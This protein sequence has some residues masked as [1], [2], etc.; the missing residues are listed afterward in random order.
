MGGGAASG[1][2]ADLRI[3]PMRTR[4]TVPTASTWC[5][6]G[7]RRRPPSSPHFIRGYGY[8]GSSEP[9][10]LHRSGG[11]WRRIQE[12]GKAGHLSHSARRLRRIARHASTT[13]ATSIPNLKDAWGIPALRISM[14]HGD[15]EAALMDDAGVA[16]AEMLEAAGAKNIRVHTSFEHSRHGDSRGGHR[17]HGQRSEKIR[18]RTT[19]TRRTTWNLFVMDGACFVSSACQNPTL[20]MMALSVRACD[21]LKERLRKKEV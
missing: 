5:A 10:L 19:S 18:A 17:A 14:T 16:A 3:A 2:F 9:E 12:G 20:T 15:N 4:P 21:H 7:I 11:F 13:S 1:T 8:Q 6:F